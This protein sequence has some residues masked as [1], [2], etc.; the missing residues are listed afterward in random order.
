MV[1]E[2]PEEAEEMIAISRT[3]AITAS[4]LLANSRTD[5]RQPLEMT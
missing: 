4:L 5:R 2:R 1:E 3:S